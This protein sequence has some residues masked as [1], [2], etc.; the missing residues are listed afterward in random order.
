[1]K[2]LFNY[3]LLL[4]IGMFIVHSCGVINDISTYKDRAEKKETE[5]I[6]N[7]KRKKPEVVADNKTS[8]KKTTKSQLRSDIVTYS[9]QFQGVKY[10]A[11][12]RSPQTGFD[13]SGFTCYV[14]KEYD[15]YLSPSSSAQSQQ[16]KKIKPKDAQPGDLIIF[17]NKERIQ[18]VGLVYSNDN[19]GLKVIHSTSRGV[20][21]DEIYSSKYWNSRLLYGIDVVTDVQ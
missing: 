12:G 16:G 21:I 7:D 19:N 17:G 15:I 5:E 8:K 1:M 20:V 10:T 3:I 9:E 11:A 6:Y 2:K 13:C 18:H 14:M 4:G